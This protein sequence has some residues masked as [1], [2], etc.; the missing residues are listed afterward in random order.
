MMGWILFNI[1]P[2]SLVICVYTHVLSCAQQAAQFSCD[3]ETHSPLSFCFHIKVEEILSGN[4]LV[5]HTFPDTHISDMAVIKLVRILGGSSAAAKV[6]TK[7]SC[8]N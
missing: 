2:T 1:L 3:G 4:E 7:V 6:D 5:S 8:G